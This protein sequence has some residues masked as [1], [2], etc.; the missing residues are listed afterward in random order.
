VRDRRVEPW[1]AAGLVRR[2]RATVD[3][4]RIELAAHAGEKPRMAPPKAADDRHLHRE[5]A[6]GGE[7]VQGDRQPFF[8]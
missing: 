3:R 1:H 5:A 6:C 4:D 2:P 7:Q 8:A